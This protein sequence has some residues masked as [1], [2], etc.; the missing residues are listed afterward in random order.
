MLEPPATITE[1]VSWSPLKED[2]QSKG[3]GLDWAP[4]GYQLGTLCMMLLATVR[5]G[6]TCYL[7]DEETVA[8]RLKG[9][10]KVTRLMS[11]ID[12]MW[13]FDA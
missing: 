8:R 10:F 6:R 5:Q 3:A 1:G 4:T 7:C 13:H 9:L 11:R 2:G 12:R